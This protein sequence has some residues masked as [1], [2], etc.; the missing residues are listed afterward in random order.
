[1]QDANK[2]IMLS[3]KSSATKTYTFLSILRFRNFA[4]LWGS[5]AISQ[6]G[7]NF[8]SIALFWLVLQLT[9]SALAIGILPILAM[10]P[11][12]VFQLIGGVWVDRY[13]R[14]MLMIASDAIRGVVMLVL[15]FLVATTQIQLFHIYILQVI[16][17][18]VGAF[19]SPAVSALIPNTVPK[20]GLVAAN[21]MSGLSWQV[22]QI[23]GPALAGILIAISTIG[24]AGVIFLNA[25]SFAVGALGVWLIRLPY[26][27]SST[28]NDKSIWSDLLDGFHYLLGFRTL[29]IIILI[30]VVLNFALAPFMV[31]MPVFV[32][33]V[34]GQSVEVFGF[35]TST[36]AAGAVVGSITIGARTPNTRR[37]IFIFVDTAVMGFFFAIIGLIPIL[38]VTLVLVAIIGFTVTLVSVVSAGVTQ[39]IIADEYRGRVFSIIL[40]V[41]TG[42]VP[43]AIALQTALADTIGVGIVFVLGG[44]IAV[45]T[46]L[47]GLTFREIRNL[48]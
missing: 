11:R 30:G 21:S 46:S 48:Q 43:L 1:M 32:K 26:S 20:E 35:L 37:G 42:F 13:D 28:R 14:R 3:N 31:L 2:A 29:G 40:L 16:F 36:M 27:A 19:F 44:G 18:V 17:G 7:D 33:T 10:L 15:T 38:A 34:L 8:F 5:Q 6:L 39:A 47:I 22:T 25:V 9:G 41:S 12:I 24:V 4:L 23:I 45:I